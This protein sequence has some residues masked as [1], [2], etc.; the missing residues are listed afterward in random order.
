MVQIVIRKS[1]GMEEWFMIELQ[2]ELVS[3]YDNGLSGNVLGDL[4][5]SKT[6]EP[7]MI[8]GHHMLQ[9]K[10]T[11]LDKPFGVMF[12]SKQ[13][14]CEIDEDEIEASKSYEIKAIIKRKI[15]FKNRP[16]PI[17]TRVPKRV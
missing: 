3:R 6:G 15:I 7:V 12:E 5:F 2:G 13:N 11:D 1:D 14:N 16:K 4:H 9:G 17:I 10:V 8:I